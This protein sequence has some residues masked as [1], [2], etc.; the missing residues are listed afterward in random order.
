M[1]ES[2]GGFKPISN[3]EET[4]KVMVI[5]KP[6]NQ[7]ENKNLFKDEKKEFSG[8]DI[9]ASVDKINKQL[10][11]NGVTEVKFVIHEETGS[12]MVKVIDTSSDMVIKEIPSEKLLDYAA[13]MERLKGIIVDE[14]G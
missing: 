2:P 13:G 7:L 5:R 1:I 12:L 11:D 10:L 3:N 9:E 14:K 8:E 4:S 6:D